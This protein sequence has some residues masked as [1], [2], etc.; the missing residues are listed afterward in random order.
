M[1]LLSALRR[2][3]LADLDSRLAPRFHE[4]FDADP[5]TIYDVGAAGG[6]FTPYRDG[7]VGWAP[8][9]GFEPHPESYRQLIDAGLPEHVT[10]HNLALAD[11][12]GP[13][14]FYAGKEED[15]TRSSLRPIDYIGSGNEKITIEALTL[16][17]APEHLGIPPANFIKLD[18]EGTEDLVI[19]GGAQMFAHEILGVQTEITFW[20]E[21]SGGVSFSQ[22][23]SRLSELG[24]VLFDLQI[25][26]SDVRVIGGRKDKVRSG[27]ALYL[28][29]FDHLWSEDGNQ[30]VL[31]SKLM[32]LMSLA[33]GWRYLNYALELAD[34]G[35]AHGLLDGQEFEA[36]VT[37]LTR[38]NDLSD[39][40]PSFPGRMGLALLFDSLS[41]ALYPNMKKGVPFSFNSLGNH[42]VVRNGRSN[43]SSV[44]LHCPVL[45]SGTV[46]LA[47]TIHVTKQDDAS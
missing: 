12:D 17:A 3:I 47:K 26:R 16:D 15:R 18:T 35:H 10:L 8:V 46:N 4:I 2:R 6:V 30:T 44:S 23:D 14:T 24:F 40:V 41:Y 13:I 39:R 34:F 42:W 20:T 36:I 27:D 21:Q 43:P 1:G 38:T 7:P 22:I 25:N 9:I 37:P 11:Q 31:R 32:K 19:K 5:V 29:N 45:K 33:I 28:R